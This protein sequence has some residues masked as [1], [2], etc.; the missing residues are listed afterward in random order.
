MRCQMYYLLLLT[1]IVR[2]IQYILIACL[3]LRRYLPQQCCLSFSCLSWDRPSKNH[4]TSALDVAETK[5][6]LEIAVRCSSPLTS[7]YISKS[8]VL[9]ATS[10]A[11][12]ACT[13]M[14]LFFSQLQSASQT[15]TAS[16]VAEDKK[17]KFA[18]VCDSFDRFA[19][20]LG[21]QH[22]E[23]TELDIGLYNHLQ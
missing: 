21:V 3:P 13:D 10:V 14:D 1:S 18:D 6:N 5:L 4:P 9:Q 23:H 2:W 8:C 11:A 20:F 7:I 19:Y 15:C 12:Q 22:T 17:T 16:E